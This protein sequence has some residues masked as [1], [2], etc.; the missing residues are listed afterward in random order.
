MAEDMENSDKKLAAKNKDILVRKGTELARGFVVLFQNCILYDLE[1]KAILPP[2]NQ[3]IG[4]VNTLLTLDEKIELR[5]GAYLMY[6]NGSPVT[7]DDFL[8]HHIRKME[9]YTRK[10]EMREVVFRASITLEDLLAFMSVVKEA[11]ARDDG[12]NYLAETEFEKFSVGDFRE[13]IQRVPAELQ[14]IRAYFETLINI[15]E[16]VSGRENVKDLWLAPTKRSIQD[17]TAICYTHSSIL[18]GLT[19]LPHF[20]KEHFNRLVNAAVLSAAM[21]CRLGVNRRIAADLAFTASLHDLDWTGAGSLRETILVILNIYGRDPKG[22]WRTCLIADLNRPGGLPASQLVSVAGAYERL[23]GVGDGLGNSYRPEQ[24][25]KR[26]QAEVGK[27]FSLSAVKLL[28][29]VLGLFPVGSLVELSTGHLAVVVDFPNDHRALMRPI[30][31]LIRMPSGLETEEL[32]DLEAHGTV[33]IVKCLDPAQYNL[34]VTS[35]FVEP[36]QRAVFLKSLQFEDG[37]N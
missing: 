15:R 17:L 1:N 27:R 25:L 12:A 37:G 22:E 20:R 32:M 9:R 3:V 13:K 19:R 34:N 28:I 31:R 11:F 33:R 29:N 2:A 36:E 26:I 23:A 30:V 5:I 16:L 21:C 4:A 24:A 14:A 18:L 35:F 7:I 6:V 8:F 10:L